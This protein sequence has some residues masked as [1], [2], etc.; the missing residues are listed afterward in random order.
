MND[1]KRVEEKKDEEKLRIFLSHRAEDRDAVLELKTKLQEWSAGQLECFQSSAPGEIKAGEDWRKRINRELGEADAVILIFTDP[2]L[3]WD[4]SLYEVGLFTDLKSAE[5]EKVIVCLCS[6]TDAPP[7]SPLLSRQY[8]Q[9]TVDG[10]GQFLKDLFRND[11]YFP[12]RS[13]INPELNDKTIG[14]FA[15]R[16]SGILS[17]RTSQVFYYTKCLRIHIT[18][19][20]EVGKERVPP[21]TRLEPYDDC[22]GLFSMASAHPTQPHWTWDD[23]LNNGAEG[24]CFLDRGAWDQAIA[25][26]ISSAKEGQLFQQEGLEFKASPTQEHFRPLWIRFDV[27]PDDSMTFYLLFVK[28]PKTSAAIQ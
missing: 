13:A 4:W 23:L 16:L 1:E 3:S 18:S 21:E 6:F 14:E 9:A 22:L 27:N 17:R 5:E 24:D 20:S 28:Q 7:P 2:S 10:I 12:G 19:A 15:Q 8:V 26:M 25:R 11:G